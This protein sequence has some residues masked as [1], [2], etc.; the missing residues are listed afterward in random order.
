[1]SASAPRVYSIPPG[2]P[3]LLT[4][5]Q[6]LLGGRVVPGFA[7]G[8][9]PMRLAD[10]TIFVPTRRAARELR[11]IFAGLAD[12]RAAILPTILPLGD[13][14]E[15]A[16]WFDT[17]V[18]PPDALDPPIDALE[19]LLLLTPLVQ[20]WKRRLPAHVAEMFAEDIV[21]P[22][23]S[24]EAIWLARDL[25]DLMDEIEREEADWQGLG[26]LVK[27]ELAAWWQVTLDFL[28]IVT[29]LWPDAL[30]ELKRSNPAAHRSRLIDAETER[31][32]R[33][34]PAGPV[35]AAGS[36][37]SIPATARLLAAIA[38]LPN[39]AVVLP[40]LDTDLDAA[41]W[42]MLGEADAAPSVYGHPQF[43][44]HRLLG[45]I[46]VA[47]GDVTELGARTAELGAR[48]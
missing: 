24:A 47:R 21:V 27:E 38:R 44:L 35:I 42:D 28:Q 37:G 12:G 2:A 41:A 20:A 25:A 29:G 14:D 18:P 7:L 23:S 26:G 30:G 39:G 11:S 19:R 40:G 48:A 1:M 3:F 43:G 16:A 36:T 6:A 46:G 45:A 33:A 15:D 34:P 22:A 9:D 8:D 32:M 31:L 17:A 4:L 5:A 10:A 13:V